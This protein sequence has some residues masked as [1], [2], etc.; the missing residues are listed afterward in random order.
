[1]TLIT[2]DRLKA[3]GFVDTTHGWGGSQGMDRHYAKDGFEIQTYDSDDLWHL[4]GNFN[5]KYQ[6][7]EEV[8]TAYQK[9]KTI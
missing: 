8:I 4:E 7:M 3:L 6:Y 2:I 9:H 5:I 1:M